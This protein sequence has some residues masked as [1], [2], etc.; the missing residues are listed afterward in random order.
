MRLKWIIDQGGYRAKVGPWFALVEVDG[1]RAGPQC[2][3]I[4]ANP[5]VIAAAKKKETLYI[6][7]FNGERENNLSLVDAFAAAEFLAVEAITAAATSLQ[8]VIQE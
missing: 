7:S 2:C 4:Q 1:M 6:A 8:L 5:A 3:G